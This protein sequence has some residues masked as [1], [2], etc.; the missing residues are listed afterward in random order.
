MTK[1]ALIYARVSTDEQAERGYSRDSQIDACRSYAA[2]HGLTVVAE[3]REDYSGAKLDR[4]ELDKL[5]EMI[6][7]R[8]VD[9][10]IVFSPDRLTRNLAHSLILREELMRAGVELHYCN[11]G[12]SEDTPESQMTENIEAVFAD[13]WRAKIIE[14]SKRGRRT[15]AANGKWVG[16][17]PA[18]YGYR[19]VGKR[20]EA[21][22]VIDKKESEV[23][24]RIFT[25]YAG[26]YGQPVPLQTIAAILTADRVPPP[27]RGIG[28]KNPGKGWHKG[29]LRKIVTRRAYTYG[30]FPYSGHIVTLPD[31]VFIDEETFKTAQGRLTRSKEHFDAIAK[32]RRRYLLSGHILCSCGKSMNGGAFGKDY[33][34][35][36][37]GQK[38]NKRHIRDCQEK[39]MRGEVAEGL[40]WEWVMGLLCDEKQL[41]VGLAEYA[42]R[43]E[44]DMQPKRERLAI[45]GTLIASAEGKVK[46][47][48]SAFADEKDE[49][50]AAAL[51]EEMKAASRERE[52][53]VSER[54]RLQAEVMQ[55]ELTEAER[56]QVT[57]LAAEIRN[58]L[59]EPTF[60]QKRA[61]IDLLDVRVRVLSEG[62][63]RWLKVTCGLKL[64]EKEIPLMKL[65]GSTDMEAIIVKSS[66]INRRS[67][68]PRRGGRG[69]RGRARAARRGR[70]RSCRVGGA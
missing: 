2:A 29:T 63:G 48:A 46:R 23:V 42:R 18:P 9:A 34:Y 7:R 32:R 25:L 28:K 13:Y 26:L 64:T 70:P 15:K 1:R 65:S 36:V 17:G 67:P 38:S 10:V 52:A 11:R 45:I 39:N 61:L 53:L 21:H 43:C 3:L 27:N 50:I 19:K 54:D 60:E 33:Y 55:G 31:L 47:L 8:E 56:Q 6:Q 58:K 49:L 30:E 5:R 24:T 51:R 59:S 4:P 40:V 57:A 14:G 68:A 16:L 22:L 41:E 69:R 62:N 12:K 20:H 35:Y 44:T 37:C 66:A